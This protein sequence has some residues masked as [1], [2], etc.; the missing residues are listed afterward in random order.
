MFLSVILL[1]FNAR[2]FTSAIYLGV[3][4]FLISLYGF[5]QHSILYSKSV[6]LVGI[7][8]INIGFLSYL[9]GPAL[10][11]Y[12]RSVLTDRARLT[13]K[14]LWHLLP[15]LIFLFASFPHIFTSWS[16][17]TAQAARLIENIN[18]LEVIRAS[19]L[20]DFIPVGIIFLSR[21]VL[22]LGYAAASA[23]LFLRWLDQNKNSEV[24]SHQRY[25]VQWLTVLLGFLFILVICQLVPMT[26]AYL[27]GDLNIF[28]A[29]E[30]LQ[31]MS[32]I[33]LAGLLISPFFFPAIL[34]GMPRALEVTPHHGN[35]IALG[36]EFHTVAAAQTKPGFEAD[37]L[38]DICNRMDKCME[39]FQPY[40]HQE[41]N[42]A[43]LSRL[44]GIPAH[45][46]AYYF[47]E[48]KEQPFNEYRNEWRIRHA[49]KLIRD[50]KSKEL[51]L[52]GI[53]KLSGFSTRNTFYTS[54]KKVE[55]ISPREYIS[56]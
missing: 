25:M 17:K 11:L 48:V 19:L 20:Y 32:G 30:L 23:V 21:L 46:L 49:K 54:F 6:V 36:D 47:R 16:Y 31:L 24:L 5:T 3:F 15:A 2:K 44:T 27:F 35:S 50:G 41:C 7:V 39:E 14:D 56:R 51:T 40:L 43:S 38:I 52:E 13:K 4:F 37:Y 55:G 9:I 42:L 1:Y 45:H 22:V 10:Y 53:G 26:E 33:G 18:N 28:F 34:Y 8:F 29:L 12:V